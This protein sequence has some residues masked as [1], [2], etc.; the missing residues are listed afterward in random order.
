MMAHECRCGSLTVSVTRVATALW[1]I[2][3]TVVVGELNPVLSERTKWQEESVARAGVCGG[4]DWCAWAERKRDVC[5]WRRLGEVVLGAFSRSNPLEDRP[6]FAGGCCCSPMYEPYVVGRPSPPQP[7]TACASPGVA[8]GLDLLLA[9]S[10]P[11]A[12]YQ[13]EGVCSS[14]PATKARRCSVLPPSTERR[15]QG[16][17]AY[18]AARRSP[19]LIYTSWG[20]AWQ[21]QK[22]RWPR[23]WPAHTHWLPPSCSPSGWSSSWSARE[24]ISGMPSGSSSSSRAS[25][26]GPVDSC[27]IP[28]EPSPRWRHLSLTMVH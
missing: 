24:G 5:M 8:G 23:L 13:G 4:N 10:A 16:R 6:V 7:T 18:G 20:R 17:G 14:L 26:G 28:K 22:P 11:A 12:L 19:A 9:P 27:H 15:W 3:S 21:L 25:W 1:G 2:A